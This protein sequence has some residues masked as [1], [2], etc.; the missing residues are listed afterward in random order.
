MDKK[1]YR[2]RKFCWYDIILI[3]TAIISIL[4]FILSYKSYIDNPW[5]SNVLTSL[6]ASL[7]FAVGIT[8]LFSLISA[9]N[10]LITD[11]KREVTEILRSLLILSSNISLIWYNAN[12]D[13]KAIEVIESLPHLY[14]LKVVYPKY[15][16]EYKDFRRDLINKVKNNNLEVCIMEIHEMGNKT[17]QLQELFLQEYFGAKKEPIGGQVSFRVNDPIKDYGVLYSNKR[18]KFKKILKNDTSI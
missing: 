7:L 9:K 8:Y 2:K 12:K 10:I 3:V 14:S 5:L 11:A 18:R 15:V 16:E 13:I 17:L 6:A 4:L 1:K